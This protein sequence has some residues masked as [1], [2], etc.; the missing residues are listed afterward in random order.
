MLAL[1][2]FWRYLWKFP[3]NR[4]AKP[5]WVSVC[6]CCCRNKV[7]AKGVAREDEKLNETD[8]KTMKVTLINTQRSGQ[9]ESFLVF[10]FEIWLKERVEGHVAGRCA[11]GQFLALPISEEGFT[12][13][14]CKLKSLVKK[15]L[16]GAWV[17]LRLAD[18]FDIGAKEDS[19]RDMK[20]FDKL[21]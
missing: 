1:I 19:S 15:K 20:V 16:G 14:K 2:Q 6:V 3:F 13:W 21:H 4:N 7:E 12:D 10:F 5:L 9:R 11:A 8:P 18:S 17:L